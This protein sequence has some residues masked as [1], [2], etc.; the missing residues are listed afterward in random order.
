MGMEGIQE[1]VVCQA[2]PVLQKDFTDTSRYTR[3]LSELYEHARLAPHG[4]RK[5][6][7]LF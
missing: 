4:V 3:I 2:L 6:I 5:L 1:R 7:N